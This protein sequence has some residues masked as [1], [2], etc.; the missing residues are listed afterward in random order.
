MTAL[1]FANVLQPGWQ[2]LKRLGRVA[3]KT[4]KQTVGVDI[5]SS[6]IKLVVLGPG[7]SAGTR[8]VVAHQLVPIPES[9]EPQFS[10]LLK[11]AVQNMKLP[12]K[13]VNLSVSGQWVITR[14]VEMPK[15]SSHEL[16]QALP[17]EAQRYLPFNVQD[18]VLD[19][20]ALGAAEG[21]KEWVL[22][23]ACKRDLLERRIDWIRR[24]GL[25]PGVID[26]DALALANAYLAQANGQASKGT[27]ALMNV[28]T[29]WTNLVVLNGEAPYLV[30]DIPWGSDKLVRQIAEHLGIE[31]SAVAGPLAQSSPLS[32]HM[33]ESMKLAVESL[34]TELQLSFDFFESRFGPPPTQLMV[35]GGVSQQ[36]A[37][38]EALKSHLPQTPTPWSPV[39]SLSAQFSVAYG[40]ALRTA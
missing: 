39:G 10:D 31:K 12:L 4:P 8:P 33:M 15:L 25:E 17:F 36:I 7:K 40:L 9:S 3:P 23:V 28:G 35:S 38:L 5:G 18:V 37:F 26:V 21:G 1:P 20:M 16:A 27:H 29:Q 30:R 13:T 24:A 32:E 19:G 11:T 22:I 6:S 14:V 34:T 2:A